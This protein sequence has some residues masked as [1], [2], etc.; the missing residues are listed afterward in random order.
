MGALGDRAILWC[1]EKRPGLGE[2][3]AGRRQW[4]NFLGQ[5][6]VSLSKA[7]FAEANARPLNNVLAVIGL[8]AIGGLPTF[9]IAIV[10]GSIGVSFI[11]SGL[12]V[13]VAGVLAAAGV[14]PID[15]HPIKAIL[16]GPPLA[17]A[18][19]IALGA[20][21]GY[22]WLAVKVTRKVLAAA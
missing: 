17:G 10:L 16:V 7:M 15:D 21:V 19:V 22:F 8:L 3:V 4:P 13:F 6:L 2:K 1:P 18:G 11:V 14:L 9:A 12:A 20:L 5:V